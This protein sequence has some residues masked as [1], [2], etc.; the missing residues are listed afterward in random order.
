MNA[1]TAALLTAKLMLVAASAP[2]GFLAALVIRRASR[3]NKLGPAMVV[4]AN[5]ALGAWVALVMPPTWLLPTTF[6][7]GWSLL[8]LSVVDAL[9]FRL[10]D[11]LTLP[12]IAAGLT[13]SFFLPGPDPAGHVIGAAAGFGTLY[14]IILL[15][16]R[17]RRRDGL[18]LGDAKLGAVAGAWLGWQALPF[19]VLLA[20]AAGLIWYGFGLIRRGKTVLTEQIPFGVPLCAAI[21]LVWLYGVPEIFAGG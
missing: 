1:M 21:W 18:G 20:C 9:A 7:L 6:L 5:V 19:V 11:I 15:Y 2:A 17:V 8:I 3:T 4:T 12:L 10:P 16:R 13:V 14:A